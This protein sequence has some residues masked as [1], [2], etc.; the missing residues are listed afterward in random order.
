MHEKFKKKKYFNHIRFS[1]SFLRKILLY[2]F[3]YMN[4]Y[5]CS[6]IESELITYS[7]LFS[8]QS[9]GIIFL[10]SKKGMWKL[11]KIF[12]PSRTHLEKMQIVTDGVVGFICNAEHLSHIPCRL[13]W[14]QKVRAWPRS[15]RT[16]HPNW[17]DSGNTE[18]FPWGEDRILSWRQILWMKGRFVLFFQ[19]CPT[20]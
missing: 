13:P 10:S 2:Y 9:K 16:P 1:F 7:K 12:S 14:Q 17:L 3:I 8:V 19:F 6:L 15:L 18:V 20:S 11:G 5:R 4:A